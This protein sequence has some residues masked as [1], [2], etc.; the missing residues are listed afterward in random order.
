[1][2]ME[3]DQTLGREHTM[4]Y[5][6]DILENCTLETY[7]VTNKCHS[8]KLNKFLKGPVSLKANP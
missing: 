8:N 6:G 2:M 7:N 1:M 3:G 4:Q 5:T